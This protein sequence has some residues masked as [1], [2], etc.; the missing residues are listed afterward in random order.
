[1][2]RR[3]YDTEIKKGIAI[4]QQYSNELVRRYGSFQ[5]AFDIMTKVFKDIEVSDPLLL[6]KHV[7]QENQDRI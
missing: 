4:D 5:K 7:N 3:N 2:A 1:M 6:V